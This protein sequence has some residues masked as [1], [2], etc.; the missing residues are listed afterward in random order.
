MHEECD[1]DHEI[2]VVD[3]KGDEFEAM[4]E[5][6]PPGN[7]FPIPMPVMYFESSVDNLTF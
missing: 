1:L 3:A 2:E 5:I 7:I 4:S 6:N